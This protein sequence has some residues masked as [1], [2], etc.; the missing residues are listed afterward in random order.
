MQIKF[1]F[2]QSYSTR[3]LKKTF[4]VDQ[5]LEQYKQANNNKKAN[6]KKYI[7]HTFNQALKYQMIQENCQIK[8]KNKKRETKHTKI[9]KL[10]PLLIGQS[11]QIH[12]H[13]K[14]L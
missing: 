2:I 7:N 5:I 11:E 9:T 1:H 13:E 4:S 12:F 14:I 3:S 10:T 8:P 6:I